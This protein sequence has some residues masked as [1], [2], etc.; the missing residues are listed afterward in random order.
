MKK[1]KS[2]VRLSVTLLLIIIIYGVLRIIRIILIVIAT[3]YGLI[4]SIAVWVEYV[5]HP[6]VYGL[7]FHEVRQ[8]ICCNK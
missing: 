7:M 3:Y 5:N 4:F 8:G 6:V 2:L 1:Y